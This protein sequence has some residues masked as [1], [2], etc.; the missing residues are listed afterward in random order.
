MTLVEFSGIFNGLGSE[1]T[2]VYR[3]T[4]FLRGFDDDIRTHAANE[5]PKTGVKLRFNTDVV[6]IEE[7]KNKYLVHFSDGITGKFDSILC[8]TGRKPNFTD[9]GL[10]L[11]HI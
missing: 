8:A 6:R 4:L 2:Q 10:S 9:L 5:I 11:I 7:K 3:G 1:V